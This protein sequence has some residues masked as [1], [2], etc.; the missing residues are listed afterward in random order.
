M[1]VVLKRRALASRQQMA[2]IDKRDENFT[3]Y[4]Y[5]NGFMLECSGRSEAEDEWTTQK[6]IYPDQPAL[7]EGIIDLLKLPKS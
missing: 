3:V 1:L 7:I 4:Q 5:D 2:K 6:T